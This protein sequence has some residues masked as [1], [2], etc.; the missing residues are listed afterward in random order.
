MILLRIPMT[1]A[2]ETMLPVIIFVSTSPFLVGMGC[3]IIGLSMVSNSIVQWIASQ[4][5]DENYKTTTKNGCKA[6]SNTN[7]LSR[8]G[9]MMIR[10]GK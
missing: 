4:I 9:I 1:I 8:K 6:I 2:K 5:M 10:G 7:L 3:E